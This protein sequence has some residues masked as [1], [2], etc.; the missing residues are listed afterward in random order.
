MA[1]AAVPLAK[2]ASL[3]IKTLAKPVSKQVRRHCVKQPI[4][5]NALIWV[6]QATNRMTTRM[7]M[8]SSGYKVRSIAKLE[9]EAALSQGADI[10]SETFLFTVS[11]GIVVYEY[12]K[13]SAKE[14]KKEAARLQVI[15][16][17]AERLQRKL[18]SLDKRLVALEEYAKVNRRSILGIGIGAN[19]DYVEPDEVVP[20]AD[21][22]VDGT[23]I[24]SNDEKKTT[25]KKEPSTSDKTSNKSQRSWRWLWPF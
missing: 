25:N 11:G 23:N 3:L 15:R 2:L 8:W 16:D 20:I 24:V 22:E 21:K 17:D 18:V 7:T 12:N 5:R 1:P 4:T 9:E 10:L 6:G 14:K 19:G 13:S